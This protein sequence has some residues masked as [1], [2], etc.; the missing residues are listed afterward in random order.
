[1]KKQPAWLKYS[2]IYWS[3]E[4]K[5]NSF[6]GP[7][8]LSTKGKHIQFSFVCLHSGMVTPNSGWKGG[9][10]NHTCPAEA[11]PGTLRSGGANPGRR[12]VLNFHP[13]LQAFVYLEKDPEVL[14]PFWGLS[15]KPPQKHFFPAMPGS[16]ILPKITEMQIS[17]ELN[18]FENF[19]CQLKKA[20]YFVMFSLS[21][22]YGLEV[23]LVWFKMQILV[24]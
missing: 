6:L 14:D 19:K 2:W 18:S 5:Q 9:S 16:G 13:P 11:G 1:M 3:N 17:K 4:G 24:S 12:L 23:R 15:N 21:R 10:V 20:V 22:A 7:F 8:L